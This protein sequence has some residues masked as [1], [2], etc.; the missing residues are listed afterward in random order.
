MRRRELFERTAGM[1][2]LAA[3]LAACGADPADM[4]AAV[5]RESSTT[6]RLPV[7]ELAVGE[8]AFAG[9]WKS[10]IDDDLITFGISVMGISPEAVDHA[11]DGLSD[12][13]E[14]SSVLARDELFARCCQ[15]D[16]RAGDV[17]VVDGWM[18]PITLA[19][20]AGALSQ[21]KS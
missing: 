21:F 7:V 8:L 11:R 4:N 17:V 12:L 16:S 5:Q 1:T 6:V 2:G 15:N 14:G 20:L 18:V 9:P 3:L 10:L 13:P 19:G